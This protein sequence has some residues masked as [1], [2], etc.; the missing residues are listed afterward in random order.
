M[1]G[2]L[3]LHPLSFAIFVRQSPRGENLA[4]VRKK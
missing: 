4:H 2:I 1:S 3:E